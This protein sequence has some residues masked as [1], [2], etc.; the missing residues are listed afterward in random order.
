MRIL[1]IA[2]QTAPTNKGFGGAE[3]V[4]FEFDELMGDRHEVLNFVP[5][6][7]DSAPFK[8]QVMF[9]NLR[10]NTAQEVDI[11][12]PDIIW[13]N[14]TRQ[15]EIK[16]VNSLGRDAIYVHHSGPELAGISIY[17]WTKE[18][19]LARLLGSTHLAVGE[20]HRQRWNKVYKKALKY[21]KKTAEYFGNPQYEPMITLDDVF[22]FNGSV[23]LQYAAEELQQE[24]APGDGNIVCLS[25][26]A[27]DVF[28]QNVFMF[29]EP[30]GTR[31]RLVCNAKTLTNTKDQ[32]FFRRLYESHKP[33]MICN[34][35]R[36]EAISHLRNASLSI[37]ASPYECF[38]CKT[39]ES[40]CLGVPQIIF[41][42][43][44]PMSGGPEVMENGVFRV[45]TMNRS[46]KRVEEDLRIA[47]EDL[48][49]VSLRDR[50]KLAEK[51][52]AYFTRDA[53]INNIEMEIA[54]HLERQK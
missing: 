32:Q 26:P 2:P 1:H 25:R 40:Y 54:H 41:D 52:R 42:K 33:Y 49:H 46:R 29:I 37:C 51:A 47:T 38:P 43:M 24:V 35:S 23:M 21:V 18:M 45:V 17:G 3:K 7:T 4:A 19:A 8:G 10:G 36:E 6:N 27:S 14:S 34:V 22:E 31:L 20:K 12:N 39:V 28:L 30:Y 16:F 13:V 9:T 50:Q 48:M 11:F 44:E 5:F 15:K 53:V